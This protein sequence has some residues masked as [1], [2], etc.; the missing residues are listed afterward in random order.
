[1]KPKQSKAK[2]TKALI[3]TPDFTAKALELEGVKG[4]SN[5]QMN[6][7]LKKSYSG[8]EVRKGIMLQ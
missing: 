5:K 6:Q 4:L 8:L 1:M 7:I 2:S 3:Y